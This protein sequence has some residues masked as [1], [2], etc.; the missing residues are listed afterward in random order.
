MALSPDVVVVAPG[1]LVTADHLNDIRANLDRIDGEVTVVESQLGA[2]H[3]RNG[4][5]L[6]TTD[7]SGFWSA[8]YGYTFAVFPIVVANVAD[9]GLPLIVS[10]YVMEKTFF[11]ARIIVGNTGAVLANTAV[12]LSWIAIQGATA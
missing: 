11:S 12:R 3:V 1:E 4:L 5:T 2:L 6:A 8:P 9:T 7:A 10:P